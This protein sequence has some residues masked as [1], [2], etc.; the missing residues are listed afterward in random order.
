MFLSLPRV[1]YHILY[2]KSNM[3]TART[4][5]I[6]TVDLLTLNKFAIVGLFVEGM[7]TSIALVDHVLAQ[8]DREDKAGAKPNAI[9]NLAPRDKLPDA[10]A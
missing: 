3:S 9:I 6:S 8:I 2:G 4:S 1:A 10:A 5:T 7:L